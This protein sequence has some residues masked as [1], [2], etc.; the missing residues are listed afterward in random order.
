MPPHAP[1][2]ARAQS[3]QPAAR[4][5]AVATAMI[6][7]AVL[8]AVPATAHETT[9][10]AKA[11]EIA[12][13]DTTAEGSATTLDG[14]PLAT[15]VEAPESFGQLLDAA[16]DRAR[17]IK[18]IARQH[19]LAEARARKLAREKAQARK[20][21][22]L[23]RASRASLRSTVVRPV[24]GGYHLTARFGDTSSRWGSGRHTGLDFACGSGTPVRVVA[25]G[26]ILST[27]YEG[28]YGNRIEVRHADGTVTTYSHLSSIAVSGGSV[29]AGRV[30]G[31]VGSTGNTTGAHLHFEV[32]RGG[33]FVDPERW[34]RA[35]F[36]TY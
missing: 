28:A 15:A 32:T 22:A 30:I 25:D 14:E 16:H 21:A 7:A 23:V 31:R 6:A 19:R 3:A 13:P 20:H 9:L 35:H 17:A 1:R 27:G 10:E 33:T 18:A 34:L 5:F 26:V 12:A 8:V 2:H 24:A 36:V 4:L 29:K 11:T